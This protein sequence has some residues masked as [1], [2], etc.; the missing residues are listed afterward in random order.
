MIELLILPQE[1]CEANFKALSIYEGANYEF[2]YRVTL[3]NQY[4]AST[5]FLTTHAEL[6]EGMEITKGWF[7]AADFPEEEI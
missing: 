1:F 4:V 2:S 5:S 3:L 7:S 6:F